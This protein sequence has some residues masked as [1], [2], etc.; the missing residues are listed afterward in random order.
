[1]GLESIRGEAVVEEY[2]VNATAG[3][4]GIQTRSGHNMMRKYDPQIHFQV[5][6]RST[7]RQAGTGKRTQTHLLMISA[8]DASARTH[9]QGGGSG[10]VC[11]REFG[12]SEWY[13]PSVLIQRTDALLQREQ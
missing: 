1:M 7:Q 6:V 5:S 4:T 10:K 9:T 8:S 11:L 12:S 2:K 3:T 13:V